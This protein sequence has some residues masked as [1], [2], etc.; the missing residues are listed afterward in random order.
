MKILTRILPIA[1]FMILSLFLLQAGAQD[2]AKYLGEICCHLDE[3]KPLSGVVLV[4]ERLGVLAFG[5]GYVVLTGRGNSPISGTGFVGTDTIVI[6]LYGSYVSPDSTV[7][8]FYVRH[9][10]VDAQTL[11]GTH[12]T[13]IVQ[14]KPEPSEISTYSGSVRIIPCDRGQN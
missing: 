5:P 11:K 3:D 13:M 2:E 9:I 14:T 1:A 6:S 7:S 10:V 8:S 12:T 4:T